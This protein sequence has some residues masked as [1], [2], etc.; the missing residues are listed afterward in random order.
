MDTEQALIFTDESSEFTNIQSGSPSID[1][2]DWPLTPDLTGPFTTSP[3]F[4]ITSSIS[5]AGNFEVQF[6]LAAN[7]WGVSMNLGNSTAGINVRQGIWHMIDTAK[8]ASA[9]PALSGQA[10]A[11]DS[12]NPSDNVGGLPP[13]NPCNWD[14]MF[15]E[16]F[17]NCSNPPAGGLA[18]HLGTAAGAN[19]ITWLHAPGSADMN[20]AAAHFVAAGIATGCDGGTGAA[21]CISSNDSRLSGISSAALSNPVNFF[22]VQDSIARLDLHNGVAEQICYMFTGSYTVPCGYL[23]IASAL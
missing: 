19:G 12:P 21:S 2:T 18:Y 15:P 6:M 11:L 4:R 17:S 22:R 1:F 8:F 5:Q 20:A 14:P 3:N 10:V 23:H 16:T 9:E 13:V 7:F